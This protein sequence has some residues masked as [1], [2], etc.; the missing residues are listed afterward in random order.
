MASQHGQSVAV[1]LGTEF[2]EAAHSE[3]ILKRPEASME[4][5]NESSVWTSEKFK[6][7]TEMVDHHSVHTGLKIM[8]AICSDYPIHV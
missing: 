6:C 7:Q 4:G 1:M 2:P 8:T 5:K 3:V